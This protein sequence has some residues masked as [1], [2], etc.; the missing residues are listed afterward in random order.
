MRRQVEEKFER[1]LLTISPLLSALVV[2]S[3]PASI[4]V[5]MFIG[6]RS[7]GFFVAQQN[8]LG[9]ERATSRRC[10]PGSSC[11]SVRP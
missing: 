8:A 5:T 2:L 3:L 7:Q 11:Q 10:T 6:S 4:V 1:L 9:A